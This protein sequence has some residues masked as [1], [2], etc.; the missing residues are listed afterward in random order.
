MRRKGV[1]CKKRYPWRL[2]LALLLAGAT[3]VWWAF[4]CYVNTKI[5]PTLY[6]LAE[7]EAR[8]ATVSAINEAVAAEMQREPA[9][10]GSLYGCENGIT[11]LDTVSANMARIRL[12]AAV[13]EA[14]Q[15]LPEHSWV[16]PFGSLTDNTLLGGL[17]PGWEVGLRPQGYVEGSIEEETVS[18]AINSVHCT[19]ALALRVTVNMILDGQTSTLAV[20]TR[21]PLASVIVSSD[22]PYY[23]SR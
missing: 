23:Y 6:E 17:G 18:L 5:K 16:I 4:S 7:Y 22:T 11:T 19:A 1:A 12:V 14:M 8:A 21:L 10:Y 15:A 13:E 2:W 3:A 20:E 9:L